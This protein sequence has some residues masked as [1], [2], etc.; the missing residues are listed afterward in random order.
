M[1]GEN[2]THVYLLIETVCFVCCRERSSRNTKEKHV[3]AGFAPGPHV[4]AERY[5][6]VVIC[7]KI[8]LGKGEKHSASLQLDFQ[9][10][11]EAKNTSAVFLFVFC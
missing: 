10:S 1:C 5:E 8:E 2:L 3:G 6:Y 4:M 7:G 9:I 11:V